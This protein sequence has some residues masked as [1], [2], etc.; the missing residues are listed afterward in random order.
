MKLSQKLTNIAL[1]LAKMAPLEMGDLIV[2]DREGL[3]VDFRARFHPEEG[4]LTFV[5]D[6]GADALGEWLVARKYQKEQESP[7]G[8]KA[9][10]VPAVGG[11]IGALQALKRNPEEAL[12]SFAEKYERGESLGER[13]V[14]L[15]GKLIFKVLPKDTLI[16]ISLKK[17]KERGRY[18][19]YGFWEILL[20]E[21]IFGKLGQRIG[22]T[23][24]NE[25]KLISALQE[26]IKLLEDLKSVDD[27]RRIIR[28]Q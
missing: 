25:E 26:N 19:K 4:N 27:L 21:S 8:K 13:F 18:E 2:V 28:E 14:N 3:G 10:I 12:D 23:S 15:I 17:I 11:T 5:N 16:R 6:M 9:N 1:K 22:M 24:Q 7:L 20:R